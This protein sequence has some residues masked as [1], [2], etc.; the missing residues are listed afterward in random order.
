MLEKNS[1]KCV[2][3]CIG[4]LLYMEVNEDT[5][6]SVVGASWTNLRFAI[7]GA[8]FATAVFAAPPPDRR[9][10]IPGRQGRER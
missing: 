3:V 2:C 7:L 10:R 1:L 4:D 6:S 9:L 5:S 8:V